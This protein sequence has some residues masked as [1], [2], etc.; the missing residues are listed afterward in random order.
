MPQA[1]RRPAKR[2]RVAGGARIGPGSVSPPGRERLT[3]LAGVAVLAAIIA[4]LVVVA[5]RGI[6]TPAPIVAPVPPEAPADGGAGNGQSQSGETN[7][8]AVLVPVI[9]AVVSLL[10]LIALIIALRKTAARRNTGKQAKLP[11]GTGPGG[12]QPVLQRNT[13]VQ[14][15]VPVCNGGNGDCLFL[16]IEEAAKRARVNG[17][18]VSSLRNAVANA[19]NDETLQ[20]SRE[21]YKTIPGEFPH[22]RDVRD[23]NDLKQVMRTPEYWG[24]DFALPVIE[25]ETGL[26]IRVLSPDAGELKRTD[27]KIKAGDKYVFLKLHGSHYEL[28]EDKD[29]RESV[30]V[31]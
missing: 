8:K 5:V 22:M 17:I 24:D 25:K 18:T 10:V 30:F 4:L 26:K 14:N 15:L 20:L 9:I 16:S 27:S 1:R 11:G 13:Q 23:L 28:L 7:K 12:N 6:G 29:T 31:A 21:Y 19:A 3:R 2:A